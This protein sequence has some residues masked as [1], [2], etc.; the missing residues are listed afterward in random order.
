[1]KMLLKTALMS[2]VTVLVLSGTH[3]SAQTFSPNP[4]AAQGGPAGSGGLDRF[5]NHP[6][7]SES[8]S[9]R[10]SNL[11]RQAKEQLDNSNY[12]PAAVILEKALKFAPNN[13]HLNYTLAGTYYTLGNNDRAVALLEKTLESD[14]DPI[15]LNLRTIAQD[16]L[17]E[18][19][20]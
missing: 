1:M 14:V 17:N 2:S 20:S 7:L 5:P 16:M 6:S 13:A 12:S 3:V 9:R 15:P 10:V 19:K 11:Y 4:A 18:I 8:D